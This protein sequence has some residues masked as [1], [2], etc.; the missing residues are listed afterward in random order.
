MGDLQTQ[1]NEQGETEHTEA[2]KF[3]SNEQTEEG[4]RTD[5]TSSQS[6]KQAAARRAELDGFQS[7]DNSEAGPSESQSNDESELSP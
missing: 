1:S 6:N 7:N 4:Q 2:T 5:S 3:Q